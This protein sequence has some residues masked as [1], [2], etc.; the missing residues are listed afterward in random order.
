MSNIEFFDAVFERRWDLTFLSGHPGARDK[1]II[2]FL[3][4][5]FPEELAIA[6]GMLPVLLTGDPNGSLSK[7]EGKVDLG[8]PGRA[9]QIYEGLLTGRYAFASALAI[10]GG[11]RYLANTYGFLDAES[12]LTGSKYFDKLFYLERARGTYCEHRNFNLQRLNFFREQLNKY[13]GKLIEDKALADAISLV[14]ESRRLLQRLS[15][16]RVSC[17]GVVSGTEAAK[18]TLA[19][20][21]MPKEDFNHALK[22]FLDALPKK[23]SANLRPTIFLAGS[24]L[25]HLAIHEAIEASG[26]LVISESI[27]FCG[28]YQN[29]LVREDI[30]PM[31]AL[32]DR[33]TFK[34]PDAWAFGRDR[35]IELQV[36]TAKF[37][38]A[39]AVF[40]F[41]TLYD[42]STGWDY[43]DLRDALQKLHIDTYV[44]YDQ[45]YQIE[46]KDIFFE[47][48]AEVISGIGKRND[49]AEIFGEKI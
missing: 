44:L 48:V 17:P 22:N 16:L 8:I 37:S 29:D 6:S 13:T 24:P 40:Y 19:S 41:H 1:K 31:E 28:R 34:F 46:D 42:A 36:Q 49:S 23:I 32:A 25:D 27:E 7:T 5:G 14:N 10:T 12:Q 20:V 21:L 35:R 26:C 3:D 43:P 39:D 38:G 4:T 2:G 47:K 11:D 33:Y 45:P 9:R 15:E 18:I 30:D